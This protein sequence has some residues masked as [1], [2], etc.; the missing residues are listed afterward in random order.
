MVIGAKIFTTEETEIIG[1]Q[2]E[3]I[4]VLSVLWL[5]LPPPRSTKSIQ[6]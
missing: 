5:H 6:A 1:K 3:K 4:S 2:T